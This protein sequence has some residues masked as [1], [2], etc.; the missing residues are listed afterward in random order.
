MTTII[1]LLVIKNNLIKQEMYNNTSSEKI[2]IIQYDDRKKLPENLQ[3][4]INFNKEYCKDKPY[5]DFIY[6]NYHDISPYWM[7]V[8]LVKN[9]LNELYQSKEKYK[10]VMWL[11]TDATVINVKDNLIDFIEKY[12]KDKDVLISS[13]M[14]PWLGPFNAG[15]FVFRNTRISREIIQEWL[16]LYDNKKWVYETNNKWKCDGCDWSDVNYEQGSFIKYIIPKYRNNIRIVSWIVLNNP[17]YARYK[18]NVIYHFAS[19]Y[20]QYISEVLFP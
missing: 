20:K 12:I 2:C 18:Y 9:K 8:K 5:I 19:K 11:D 13:D 7:K 14:P 16:N 15:V 1:V 10:Y 4:L 17:N 6:M 3:K